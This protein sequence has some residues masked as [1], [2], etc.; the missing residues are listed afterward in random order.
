[1]E[2]CRDPNTVV[3]DQKNT[4]NFIF[5][6]RTT[7][8]KRQLHWCCA[9][10]ITRISDYSFWSGRARIIRVRF[11][12]NLRLWEK[13]LDRR[14]AK[15]FLR[16]ARKNTRKLSRDAYTHVGRAG[17]RIKFTELHRKYVTLYVHKE[18]LIALKTSLSRILAYRLSIRSEWSCAGSPWRCDR[19]NFLFKKSISTA[20]F[21]FSLCSRKEPEPFWNRSIKYSYRLWSSYRIERRWSNWSCEQSIRSKQRDHGTTN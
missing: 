18:R 7:K 10:G 2:N 17:C 13:L 3:Y 6:L 4:S 21:Y 8:K 5:P 16:A 14:F 9:S 1:M 15:E 19:F 12:H 11:G 20:P